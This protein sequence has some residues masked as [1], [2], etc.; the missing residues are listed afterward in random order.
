MDD[1]VRRRIAKRLYQQVEQNPDNRHH[2]KGSPWPTTLRKMPMNDQAVRRKTGVSIP[3]MIATTTIKGISISEFQVIYWF[4]AIFKGESASILSMLKNDIENIHT[5][6]WLSYLGYTSNTIS[7]IDL[8]E[9]YIGYGYNDEPN[10]IKRSYTNHI[11][12]P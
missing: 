10:W 3:I 6:N 12:P 9:N 7:K 8:P 5:N 1:W 4:G 11:F 2:A